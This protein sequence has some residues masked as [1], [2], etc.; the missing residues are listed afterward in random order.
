MPTSNSS[1]GRILAAFAVFIA[2]AIAA[3]SPAPAQLQFGGPAG[4]HWGVQY[5]IDGSL[6][7]TA[8]AVISFTETSVKNYPKPI[9]S[10]TVLRVQVDVTKPVEMAMKITDLSGHVMA[11]H[12]ER[13]KTGSHITDV[14]TKG[15]ITGAYLVRM[16]IGDRLA[17]TT[18]VVLDH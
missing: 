9:T 11:T 8:P 12:N 5:L 7:V 4:G 17:M 10:G 6:D 1:Y 15:W 16:M 13:L 3:T 18:V 14:D 2:I